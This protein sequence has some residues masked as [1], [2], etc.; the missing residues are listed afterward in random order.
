MRIVVLGG[1]GNMGRGVVGDLIA[2]TAAEVVIADYRF[3][4][5]QDYAEQLG[6]GASAEAVDANDPAS[7]AAVLDG[8]D[9]AVGAIGP[10]YR[11]AL[12]MATAAV[13]AGVHYVD[14]CDDY[15]PVEE[16]LG[17]HA[18]AQSAG[19][20]LITGLGWTPGLTNLMCRA[21][22]DQLDQVDE[23]KVAWAGG[24][25]G[26]SGLAVIM[27]YFYAFGGQVPTYKD[28]E[29]TQV[30]AASG[31][32]VVDFGDGVGPLTAF[33]C[34][35]PEPLTLP[36]YIKA[37]S[38]SLRGT[39]TPVRNTAQA[40]SFVESWLRLLYTI[41]LTRTHERIERLSRVCYQWQ[42]IFGAVEVPYAA[43]RVD[44]VGHRNGQPCTRSYRV[45]D[46]MQR[47]TGIPA[48]IGAHQ[49]A[50]GRVEQVGAFAPE[51]C[52]VAQPFFTELAKRD[53][54]IEEVGSG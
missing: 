22:A 28:G 51:G 20:T 52:L 25:P 29:W 7:L 2:H 54:R 19:V 31:R 42:R 43:A 9:A 27:H 14:L 49:L 15:G 4:H 34:G 38:V 47:L 53:I 26:P 45:K 10:F 30:A 18:A 21:G 24:G 16:L 44:V 41:G 23:L 6:T 40:D 39:L 48:A 32:E 13:Q 50:K 35:H 5:A 37:R 17:L 12:P 46:E 33:H 1:C 36:R 8:A 11:Y 3:Q